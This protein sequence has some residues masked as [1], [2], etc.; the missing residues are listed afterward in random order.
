MAFSL[1]LSM[2]IAPDPNVTAQAAQAREQ[3]VQ[4]LLSN[5]DFARKYA[6]GDPAAI[7]AWREVS[8]EGAA[9]MLGVDPQQVAPQPAPGVQV[10]PSG[11]GSVT[12]AGVS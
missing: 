6:A 7:R 12:T 4:G 3:A 5:S 1:A 10:N 2:P 11:V 9:A 8:D